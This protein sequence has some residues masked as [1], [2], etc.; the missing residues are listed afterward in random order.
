MKLE[1]GPEALDAFVAGLPA[2]S[3]AFPIIQE[4]AGERFGIDLQDEGAGAAGYAKRIWKL[5]TLCPDEAVR[6]NPSLEVIE[7]RT[8]TTNGGFYDGS[9]NLVC[10][11]NRPGSTATQKLGSDIQSELGEVEDNCKPRDEQAVAYFDWATLHE[12]GHA[13][14]DRLGFM[15]ARAGQAA[16]GDWAVLSGA[17]D[18][19]ITAV[20]AHVAGPAADAF[21]PCVEAVVGGADVSMIEEPEGFPGSWFDCWDALN[22]WYALATNEK[23]WW[24]ESD[25]Q[26][27]KLGDGYIYQEAYKGTWVRYAAAARKRGLTGYQFRAPGEWFAELYAAY[28]SGKLKPAHPSAVWLSQV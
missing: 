7:R 10:I 2:S 16:F 1:G 9:E 26:K 15:T 24:S 18:V 4:L 5:L 28:H 17:L 25:S 23:V 13:V 8:S 14:D 3:S 11:Q 27:L 12:V 22:E 20:A 19:L 6:N 21:R